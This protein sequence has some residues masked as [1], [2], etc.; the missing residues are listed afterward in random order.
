MGILGLGI[1]RD[2]DNNATNGVGDGAV[3][4]DSDDDVVTLGVAQAARRLIVLT[5]VGPQGYIFPK[6]PGKMWIVRNDCTGYAS[7]GTTVNNVSLAP[8]NTYLVW[9][10]EAGGIATATIGGGG[11]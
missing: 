11:G 9:I 1:S 2:P 8:A 4:L 7:V 6:D 10:N 5:G 3:T